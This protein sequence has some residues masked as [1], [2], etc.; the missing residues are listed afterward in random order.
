VAQHAGV[1]IDTIRYYEKLSLLP[2][3]PRSRGGFRLFAGDAIER[4]RFVKQAQEIGFSLDEIRAL[5]TGGGAG[6]CRQIRDLLHTKLQDV[7]QRMKA[8]RGFKR[9]LTRHLRACE[10][11]LTRSGDAANCP[12]VA[13]IIGA[14]K[15]GLRD[16]RSIRKPA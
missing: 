16:E 2:R 7:D 6:E 3:A 11:E 9:V 14:A 1:S 8:L 5:L 12:V 10:E 13:E 15:K 4:V